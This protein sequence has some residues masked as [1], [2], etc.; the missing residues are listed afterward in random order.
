MLVTSG[1]GPSAP[2]TQ[3]LPGP[4]SPLLPDLALAAPACCRA[5]NITLLVTILI[6]IFLLLQSL[7]QQ[8]VGEASQRGSRRSC[9]LH[10]TLQVDV[11]G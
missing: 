6:P 5:T 3:A 7:E 8:L 1:L 4:P 9:G 11:T 10:L 2:L